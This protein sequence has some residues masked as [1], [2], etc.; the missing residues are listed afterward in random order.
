MTEALRLLP[1]GAGRVAIT[2][3]YGVDRPRPGGRPWVMA[4]FVS[5]VDGATAVE[6]RSR[7]LGGPSDLA[8]FRALRAA[9]DVIL[10]GAGTVRAEGYGPARPSSEVRA[11]RRAAG[12]AEVPAI[13]V[14]SGRL[15]LDWGSPLFHEA[16]TRTIV[17]TTGGADARE[18]AR[19]AEV[20]DVLVAG[21]RALDLHAVVAELGRRGA[22]VVLTE[23]G[24]GL[25]GTL[26]E[27]DL[28]DEMCLTVAPMLVA[29]EAARVAHSATAAP[30][31]MRLASALLADEGH[32]L[33]RYVRQD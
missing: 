14:V 19:A 5:S 16:E 20:A 32:L 4:N 30:R 21:D 22:G 11:A 12:R 9:A 26:V 7:A 8:A 27:A 23:G 28:I 33:L 6:G 10:V 17:V 29:G 25:L 13:A 1:D 15:D 31:D 18:R 3:V 2:G 24:P